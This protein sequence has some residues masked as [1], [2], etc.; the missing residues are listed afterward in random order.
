VTVVPCVLLDHLYQHLNARN[1]RR[2]QS[3]QDHRRRGGA[4]SELDVG[5]QCLPSVGTTAGSRKAS[6]KSCPGQPLKRVHLVASGV[7]D[8]Q[9]SLS[10][11]E[12]AD[13]LIG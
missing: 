1:D 11:T 5:L 7:F 3:C 8:D 13:D 12:R 6:S 2:R 9:Y 10:L 4:F